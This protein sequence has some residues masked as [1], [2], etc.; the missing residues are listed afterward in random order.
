MV[1]YGEVG[2]VAEILFNRSPIYSESGAGQGEG[3]DSLFELRL[4]RN[5]SGFSW[6]DSRPF[7]PS[8]PF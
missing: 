6:V 2:D 4:T 5:S 7:L 3:Y 1:C 8:E